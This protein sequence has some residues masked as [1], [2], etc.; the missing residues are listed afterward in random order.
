MKSKI[1]IFAGA[2]DP[3]HA[4]HITFALQAA[5]EAKLTKVVFLPERRP[6]NK[7]AVEHFGHRTAMITR[8]IRPYQN[9]ALLELPDLSFDV[10]HTLPKLQ[11]EFPDAALVFLMGS[12]AAQK[13][14][15]PSWSP[16]ELSTYLQTAGLIIAMR[17]SDDLTT[18]Q[19]TLADLPV[20][21]RSVHSITTSEQHISSSKIRQALRRNQPTTGLLPSV[22]RYTRDQWLY[23]S[24]TKG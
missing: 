14:T 2:F 15:S 20:Q 24:L 19:K 8:A 18:I 4:G 5:K 10:P 13:L 21:P 23:A 7:P 3:V 11:K 1:G 9:L 22:Y 16:D 12:D 17:K 6:R